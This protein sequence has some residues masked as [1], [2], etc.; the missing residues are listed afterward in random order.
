VLASVFDS[1]VVYYPTILV[2]PVATGAALA[3]WR[4]ERRALWILV[5]VIA[6]F[7]VFD[8][9]LDDTRIDDLPFFV[10]LGLVM[11]GLGLLARFAVARVLRSRRAP[12]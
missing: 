3:I 6:A 11:F 4:P 12:A 9:A 5:A 10:V 2:L 8:F 7:V 1:G